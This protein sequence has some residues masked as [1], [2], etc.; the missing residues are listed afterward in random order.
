MMRVQRHIAAN[1]QGHQWTSRTGNLPGPA[2]FH[3]LP[4]PYELQRGDCAPVKC[5]EKREIILKMQTWQTWH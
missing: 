5:T 2:G 3:F 4:A 1:M